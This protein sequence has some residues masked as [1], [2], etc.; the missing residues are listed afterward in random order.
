MG[1][2]TIIIPALIFCMWLINEFYRLPTK[3]AEIVETTVYETLTTISL[4]ILLIAIPYLLL[5]AI[6]GKKRK[7]KRK[8]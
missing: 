3:I 5:T 6:E 8:K 7:K 1:T 2:K 4:L